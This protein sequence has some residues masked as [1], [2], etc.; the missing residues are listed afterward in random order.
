MVSLMVA[1]PSTIGV[2]LFACIL[3]FLYRLRQ[4][5]IEI[6]KKHTEKEQ[7]ETARYVSIYEQESIDILDQVRNP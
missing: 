3:V 4:S 2:V 6:C 5:L 1:V 7:S